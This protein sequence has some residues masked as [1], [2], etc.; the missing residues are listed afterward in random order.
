VTLSNDT[1][2]IIRVVR[3]SDRGIPEGERN[4][5]F[6]HFYRV[7]TP[8]AQGTR[9]GLAIATQ[10]AARLSGKI[11]LKTPESGQGLLAEIAMPRAHAVAGT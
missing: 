9:L 11:S 2:C 6:Q 10:T 1:E 7:G 5:V 4:C 3:D 8:Q